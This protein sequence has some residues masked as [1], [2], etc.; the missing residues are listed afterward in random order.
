MGKF[1]GVLL[2]SDYDHTISTMD[3]SIPARN[4]EALRYF[5]RE[6]GTF[7]VVSGR[8]IPLFRSR[9]PLL[10]INAPCLLYNGA[11]CYDFRSER[12][13]FSYTLPADAQEILDALLAQLSDVRIEVQTKDA[14]YAYTADPLRDEY[15]RRCGA[16]CVHGP[17]P[18]PWVKLVV[19]GRFR[20]VEY[21]AADSLSSEDLAQFDRIETQM[22]TLCKG[23]ANV[24]RSMGRI[25]ECWPIGC[26][27][28]ASAR[29][30][31]AML[32]CKTLVGIGDA[33]N[34]LPLLDEADF[35]FCP[36]DCD[37]ALRTRPYRF[38]APCGEGAVAG[39]IEALEGLL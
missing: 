11:M 19:Y 8:S 17:A 29:R 28:G 37:P 35:A 24:A 1:T 3:G 23:R 21:D 12:L 27:K 34:D 5:I 9:V 30:L 10:P 36:G 18:Q 6:G 15:L 7:S 22:H 20:A 33:P 26:D 38:A 2:A 4:V 32:G 14:C 25:V 13:L 39:A 31:A 16:P